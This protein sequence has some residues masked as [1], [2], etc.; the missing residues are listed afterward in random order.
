MQ[1]I[2][3]SEH[4]GPCVSRSIL[5][6]YRC[7]RKHAFTVGAWVASLMM[8]GLHA[9][10]A[11]FIS[12]SARGARSESRNWECKDNGC[13]T[14]IWRNTQRALWMLISA[15]GAHYESRESQRL[16]TRSWSVTEAPTCLRSTCWVSTLT[17]RQCEYEHLCL[18][19][20][21]DASYEVQ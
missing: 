10:G 11:L 5:T 14:S 19:F 3:S 21:K 1:H 9:H 13:F 20:S 8:A 7:L 17:L 18:E 4:S 2:C 16:L 15:Q 6:V 12:Q